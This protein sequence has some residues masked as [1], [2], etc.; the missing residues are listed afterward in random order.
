[1]SAE[2]TVGTA[3]LLDFSKLKS[4]A[5]NVERDVI[6]VVIQ[7][8]DTLEV[9]IIAYMDLEALECTFKN[10]LATL[11]STSRNVLWEKGKTSGDELAFV[12]ARINCEQNSLVILVKPKAGACHVEDSK[13][14]HY[15]SCYYRR[16]V[17]DEKGFRLEFI[18]DK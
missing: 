8:V 2:I 7:D 16:I 6:P 13:G 15:S 4:I 14:K 18:K 11:W 3:C 17:S 1:M 5:K 12:E 10:K 9:L